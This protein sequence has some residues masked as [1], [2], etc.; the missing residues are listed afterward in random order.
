[1]TRMPTKNPSIPL[2]L[3]ICGESDRGKTKPRRAYGLKIRDI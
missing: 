3:S 2:L 1:L